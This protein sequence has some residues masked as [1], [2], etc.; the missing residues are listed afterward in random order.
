MPLL[1]TCMQGW[2]L[3][4]MAMLWS[5]YHCMNGTSS[6]PH[7]HRMRLVQSSNNEIVELDSFNTMNSIGPA[8]K[9]LQCMLMAPASLCIRPSS[10]SWNS[11]CWDLFLWSLIV[12]ICVPLMGVVCVCVCVCVCTYVLTFCLCSILVCY[13]LLLYISVLC[14][15]KSHT[16]VQDEMTMYV[17]YTYNT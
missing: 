8:M 17:M 16:C 5:A 4:N 10:C 3:N 12:C 14:I 11:L 2:L 7:T 6:R 9:R 1:L 13:E 15:F